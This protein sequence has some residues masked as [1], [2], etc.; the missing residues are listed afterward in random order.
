MSNHL[1]TLLDEAAELTVLQNFMEHGA[2]KS[3]ADFVADIQKPDSDLHARCKEQLSGVLQK[4]H[5]PAMPTAEAGTASGTAPAPGEAPGPYLNKADADALSSY[6]TT[7]FGLKV[8]NSEGGA[9]AY[10][11]TRSAEYRTVDHEMILRTNF[12]A[13][14][15]QAYRE[16]RME[17]TVDAVFANLPSNSALSLDLS[18]GAGIKVSAKP[19]GEGLELSA[20]L[21]VSREKGLL[22]EK[23]SSGNFKLYVG[24]KTEV[25]GTVSAEAELLSGFAEA[26]AELS[27]SGASSNGVQVT[28][29]NEADCKKF[30]SNM[31]SGGQDSLNS[32]LLCQSVTPVYEYSGGVSLGAEVKIGSSGLEDQLGKIKDLA[33]ERVSNALP[34]ALRPRAANA[35]SETEAPEAA[36]ETEAAET[37]ADEEEDDSEGLDL[38]E[39]KLAIGLAASGG[40][41][42]EQSGIQRIVT[43]SLQA[44]ATISLSGEIKNGP[45]GETSA[46][47][48]FDAKLKSTY[49]GNVL[50]GAE[51]VRTFQLKPSDDISKDMREVTKLLASH[52]VNNGALLDS[53]QE[54]FEGGQ[55]VELSLTQKLTENGLAK[56]RQA[57][58]RFSKMGCLADRK[59]YEPSEVSLT[60]SDGGQRLTRSTERTQKDLLVGTLPVD[61]ELNVSLSAESKIQRNYTFTPG[62]AA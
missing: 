20:A 5:A 37:A 18:Q 2:G 38:F 31:M 3:F 27:G 19:F 13:E 36:D 1:S 60:V 57:G 43:N 7:R 22:L 44:S 11:Q 56:H 25:K 58:N 54:L 39:A 28:F 15:Q 8:G 9:E 50:T 40:H 45:S 61:V 30:I 10:L 41:K 17:H 51:M 47:A 48:A 33:A 59:N 14:A 23:D 12:G 32:L 6:L 42:V 46:E 16:V 35:P 49:S 55:S 26:S 4:I 34:D 53:L 62:L 24:S 29:A 52:G 21:G